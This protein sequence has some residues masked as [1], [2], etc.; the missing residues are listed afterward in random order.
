MQWMVWQQLWDL[1][2]LLL[3]AT[4]HVDAW[5]TT[6]LKPSALIITFFEVVLCH[7]H[8]WVWIPEDY[9]EERNS[10]NWCKTSVVCTFNWLR[11]C[12]LS[13]WIFHNHLYSVVLLYSPILLSPFHIDTGWIFFFSITLI[14]IEVFLCFLP[15]VVCTGSILQT[16]WKTSWKA[17]P[18]NL[19]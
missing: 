8:P 18:L 12:S 4:C 2:N 10:A 9:Y 11:V 7:H 14:F 19:G 5:E 15:F 13:K 6:S 3:V 17:L 1:H 16:G